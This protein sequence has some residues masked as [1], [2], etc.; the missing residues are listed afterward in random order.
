MSKPSDECNNVDILEEN[1][2][3]PAKFKEKTNILFKILLAIGFI[4]IAISAILMLISSEEN[5]YNIL[6]EIFLAL[7]IILLAFSAIMYFFKRQF[8]KIADIAD[9]IENSVSEEDFKEKSS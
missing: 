5:K 3:S 4:F 2:R 1:R 7:S 6:S 9:E 8:D